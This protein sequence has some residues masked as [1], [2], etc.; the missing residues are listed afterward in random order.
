MVVT[1]L[2]RVLKQLEDWRR[3]WR[4]LSW[5]FSLL[6]FQVAEAVKQ[7]CYGSILSGD[8]ISPKFLKALDVVRLSWLTRLCNIV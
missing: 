7:L 3:I 4:T 8:D 1:D 2:N 5:T 6:G